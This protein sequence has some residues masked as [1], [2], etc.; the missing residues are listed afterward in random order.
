VTVYTADIAAGQAA[1]SVN[2]ENNASST[3][4]AI[5]GGAQSAGGG[6]NSALFS[7]FVISGAGTTVPANGSTNPNGWRVVYQAAQTLGWTAFVLCVP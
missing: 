4:K 2:C 1:G 3:M 6:D 5:G 7:S